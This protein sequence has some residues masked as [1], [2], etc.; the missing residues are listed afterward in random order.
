M[1]THMCVMYLQHICFTSPSNSP[2]TPHCTSPFNLISYFLFSSKPLSPIC[3][4]QVHTGVGPPTGAWPSH[5]KSHPERRHTLPSQHPSIVNRSSS[6]LGLSSPPPSMLECWLTWSQANNRSSRFTSTIMVMSRA[7]CFAP[8][9]T[10]PWHL[11]SF[12]SLSLGQQGWDV[13]VSLVAEHTLSVLSSGMGL[14]EQMWCRCPLG[15]WALHSHLRSALWPAVRLGSSYCA[16]MRTWRGV[17]LSSLAKSAHPFLTTETRRAS[18][19]S[20]DIW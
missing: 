7:H 20:H 16:L 17:V 19:P 4:V 15:G 1:I 3:A 12:H 18:F 14:G 11:R 10:H 9:L 13:D 2:Q 5:Q 6:G 8:V